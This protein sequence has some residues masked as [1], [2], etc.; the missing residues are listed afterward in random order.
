MALRCLIVDDSPPFLA[1]ARGLLERQGV[2]VVGG[3]STGA[4]ALQQVAAM[5][6]DVVLVDVDLGK[7][8]GL[9][10]ARRLHS[11]DG[12][13]APAVILISTHLQDDYAEL[14]ADSPA[15]GFVPKVALSGVA[16]RD[17]LDRGAGGGYLEPASGRDP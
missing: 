15:V 4:E 9:A 5:R 11:T 6:P 12:S 16:I 14:I 7:E 10:L 17:L 1:A 8:S 3:A 2:T 13:G